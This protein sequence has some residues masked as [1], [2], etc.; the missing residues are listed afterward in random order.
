VILVAGGTGRLGAELI[1]S[2]LADGVPVRVLTR[3]PA[4]AEHLRRLG[5]RIVTGDVRSPATLESA[6][7]GVATL[8]SAIHGFAV[9]DGGTP[10]RVDRNGNAA[11]IDVAD[12]AGAGIVLLSVLGAAPDHPLALFRMKAAAEHHLRTHAHRWTIVR[13]A[14]FAELQIDLLCRTAGAAKAPVVLGRGEN[15]INVVSVPDVATAVAASATGG[16]FTGRILDV[17][18]PEDLTL[19]QL[20]HAARRRLGRTD[21]PLRH[22]PRGL[23][24]VLAATE[25]LPRI[26]LGQI[27][28]LAV[29]LDTMPMTYEALHDP[30]AVTWRG[31]RTLAELCAPAAT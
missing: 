8:V 26:P 17:A 6:T 1:P 19:E 16:Q 4:R 28:A 14:S 5:A 12:A 2:L 18:G 30:G 22:V 31:T 20:A 21:L 13:S 29:A 25:R 24:R 10:A 23:L 9:S 15:P 11:L 7:S 27:A 3:N